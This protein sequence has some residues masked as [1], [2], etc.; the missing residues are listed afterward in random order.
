MTI[1]TD[2]DGM[3]AALAWSARGRGTT[4]PR[5]SVGSVI[6]RDGEILGGGH[7]QPGDG[8]PHAEIMALRAVR[9]AGFDA[10]GA[11]AYV[12]LEP[13]SHFGTT[14][15]CTHAL[16]E[17]G[18]ARVVCGVRDPNWEI[19]G[20]GFQFLRE[21]GIEVVESVLERE[22]ARAQDHFLTHIYYGRPFV[23]IKLAATLDGRIAAR[24][25]TSQWI[26]GESARAHV[27]ALRA[28]HDAVLCGVETV[29][30]DDA[31]LSVRGIEN[32]KQPLRVVLDSDARLGAF[33]GA[34]FS[35]ATPLLVAV[36]KGIDKRAKENIEK[37]GGSTVEIDRT[38]HGLDLAHL[39]AELRAR[40]VF[41][42]LIEGGARVATSFLRAGLCDKI[43]W[44]ASPVLL[45]SGRS[46]LED[47][48]I[49]TLAN[50]PRLRDVQIQ[51]F[52][53]DVLL[54]GYTRPLPG[55]SD[56]VPSS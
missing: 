19:N 55:T 14:P 18:I 39:L 17:A 44:F 1:R 9:E 41:S 30:Q 47:F 5:P 8:N 54:S 52:Q 29:L 33:G 3:R 53:N 38:L 7:T 21:A 35:E 27:H 28:D 36:G 23:T 6:V 11:T 15:P 16:R 25:G 40:K 32:T 49:G 10:T 13:C 12:T 24:D 2:E 20:R 37:R 50:A 56:F 22:C 48:G 42:V 26:T 43:E 4:S 45:G 34:I 46:A 51:T 31:R